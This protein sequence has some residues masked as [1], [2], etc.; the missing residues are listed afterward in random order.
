MRS[1]RV[2]TILCLLLAA[3]LA[4]CGDD[5]GDG[6]L[7]DASPPVDAPATADATPAPDAPAPDASPPDAVA[8]GSDAT[9]TP[10]AYPPGVY[11]GLV[12]VFEMEAMGEA[13]SNAD[14]QFTNGPAFGPVLA[15]FGDCELLAS[16]E[17]RGYTAGTITITGT[18][19]PVVLTP[20][21]TRPTASYMI[22]PDPTPPDLFTAGA[23]LSVSA[24]GGSVP[25]FSADVVAPAPVA[26]F[27]PPGSV[28]KSMPL[29][30][31]WTAGTGGS[32]WVWVIAFESGSGDARLLWCRT[33]D[34]G[35]YAIPA[36]ALKLIPA[37]H[38][39][40]IVALWRANE[41]LATPGTSTVH[42]VA[43]TA[44]AG[45]FVPILP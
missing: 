26:G 10:D 38:D 21:G 32:M 42:V 23:T 15:T 39:A 12:I 33:D 3:A 16:P 30:V 5:D 41:V 45:D 11:E 8:A 44:H 36:D 6:G 35:S 27:T 14:A 40:G 1:P 37:G 34:D 29:P 43:A 13:T 18:T 7:A 17:A 19:T 28:S 22:T 24:T 2:R 4:A 9:P 20:I 25:A 31:T